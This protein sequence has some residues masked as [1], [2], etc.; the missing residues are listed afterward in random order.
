M[1]ARIPFCLRGSLTA[2]RTGT[3][4]PAT[5]GDL[6]GKAVSSP[7]QAHIHVPAAALAAA[8]LVVASP[9]ASAE[10]CG[11]SL[12]DLLRAD[13]ESEY[14]M[15]ATNVNALVGNGRL[16][17]GVSLWGELTVLHWPSPSYYDHIQ[18]T[19]ANGFPNMKCDVRMTAAAGGSYGAHLRP[20]A[21]ADNMGS[22]GGMFYR[23]A[24]LPAGRMTFFRDN[25]WTPSQAYD[26]QG[27]PVL[28]SRFAND[29][30]GM[31]VEVVD[32]IPP[33]ADVLSR[34]FTVRARDGS[35]VTEWSFAWFA[36]FAPSVSRTEGLP[37]EELFESRHDFAAVFNRDT[38]I[39][40]QFVPDDE[41][42][43]IDRLD[44]LAGT[45]TP[46]ALDDAFGSGVYVAVGFDFAP[47]GFQVGA[48][49]YQACDRLIPASVATVGRDAFDDLAD[50]V[51]EGNAFTA[52]QA[53]FA[54]I[55]KGMGKTGTFR[56]LT[57]IA[58]SAT[59]AVGALAPLQAATAQQIAGTTAAA[60]K[61]WLDRR[62]LRFDDP[63]VDQF[64]RN[65][66]MT[67]RV[68]Q[69]AATHAVDASIATQPAYSFDWP[70]DGSF[71][72]LFLDLMGYPDDVAAHNRFYAD[73][74]RT[75]PDGAW[76][77]GAWATYYWADGA[78]GTFLPLWEIDETGLAL[79]TLWEHSV[80]LDDPAAKQAYLEAMFPA[81]E[82]GADLLVACRDAT[83]GMPCAA[84]EDDSIEA[85]QTLH[86]ATAVYAGLVSAAQAARALAGHEAQ[87][88]KW[89]ARAAEVKAG[90]A[91]F[92]DA[93][94]D[95]FTN[96]GWRGGEWVI[97]PA[98]LLPLDDPR[99]AAQA[100]YI[101]DV[102]VLPNLSMQTPGFAYLTE[103]L[104][105]M[106]VAA[107]EDP[108]RMDE[109]KTWMGTLLDTLPTKGTGHL[110][111]VTLT[112]DFD[113]DGTKEFVNVTSI[114]HVWEATTLA[115]A[116]IATFHPEALDRVMPD[117]PAPPPP[118]VR[119]RGDGRRP[120]APVAAAADPGGPGDAPA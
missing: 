47:D 14:L 94:A 107:R 58:G 75:D 103:S 114:P 74:Q 26:D 100:R 112:G 57:G 108:A 33:D 61:S 99:V 106:A 46:A 89:E 60:W 55:R 69:D 104:L 23:T 29:A 118:R 28:T 65:T 50:G 5:A 51:L 88:A 105:A 95:H 77:V 110:G 63:R 8:L 44:A 16:T 2:I 85:T 70:R 9:S 18:Y 76:Q 42:T 19:T 13:L 120:P 54:V 40:V 43:A 56:V 10:D 86:G 67:I 115:L 37:V 31:D 41:S 30:L 91:T 7:K 96:E 109:L 80:F 64:I 92:F 45:P 21:L 73:V 101:R 4:I 35:P 111:E 36:N 20:I 117:W 68:S 98:M 17:A 24:A 11:G 49:A 72:N 53:D 81:I 59:K 62:T 90:I 93:S 15:G 6:M 84:S 52:C 25:D 12:P 39:L 71:I 3:I 83:N 22:F 78:V 119:V 32:V 48:D 79:W 27:V 66:L 113:G 38:G 102:K 116:L 87:A 97:F 82:R 1:S 34:T